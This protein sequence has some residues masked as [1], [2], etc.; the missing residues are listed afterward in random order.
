MGKGQRQ[1]EHATT[2]EP[3]PETRETRHSL[4]GVE[5]WQPTPVTNLPDRYIT[6]FINS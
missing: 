1:V 5:T 4:G 3:N 2:C 6:D